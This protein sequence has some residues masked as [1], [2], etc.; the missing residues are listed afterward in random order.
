LF[1]NSMRTLVAFAA[2][3]SLGVAASA[4]AQNPKSLGT[5]DSW[6]AIELPEK[7]SKVCYMVARPAKSLPEGAKRN[8]VLLTITHR[9]AAKQRDEVSFQAGYPYKAGAPVTVEIEKKKFELFT[10]PEADPDAAW[11]RDAAMDKALVEA[12]RGGK[13]VL[14]K[15]TS[16]RGTDTAD[17]F[18]LAGF[19][20]A[21]AEIGKA[22][23]IK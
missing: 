12:M 3:A 23:G 2:I 5:F 13:S 18:S 21:Y 1:L 22:C 14:V 15:G 4:G 11:S 10:K 16:A 17:S 6:T 7:S 9:P 8:D 19:S 20:K